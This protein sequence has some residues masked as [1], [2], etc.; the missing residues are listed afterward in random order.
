MKVRKSFLFFFVICLS[1]P[2]LMGSDLKDAGL[3]KSDIALLQDKEPD[4]QSHIHHHDIK[5]MRTRS[6]NLFVRYNPVSLLFG[7]LMYAYQGYISPQLPSECLYVE[8]CSHFSKNL[9]AEYGLFKGVFTTSDRLMRC[10][11]VSALDVHPMMIDEN[12]GKVI[13]SVEIYNFRP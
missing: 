1:V 4:E 11:R 9:I 7:G 13:E 12:S 10:N 3:H 6:S 8:S 5:F 2:A